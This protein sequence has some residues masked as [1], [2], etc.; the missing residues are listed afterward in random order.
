ML[1]IHFEEKV[2][3]GLL[4]YATRSRALPLRKL[5]A[6]EENAAS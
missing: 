2:G 5:K 4:T 3:D 6:K 1:K